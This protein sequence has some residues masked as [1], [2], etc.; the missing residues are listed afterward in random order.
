MDYKNIII[1]SLEV[2]Y[3]NELINKEPFKAKA[4]KNV[5]QQLKSYSSEIKS[6]DDLKNF[7]G[8][9]DKIYK[10]CV[11][12]FE[13]GKLQKVD[14][15]V[16]N[17]VISFQL[18]NELQLIY[19]VGPVK[20]N[21]LIKEYKVKSI[22]DLREKCKQNKDILNSSQKIGLKYYDDLIQRIPR[23]EMDE[24]YHFITS[25]ITEVSSGK[26]VSTLVG[27]YRRLADSS[28][29][30]D[31][32]ITSSSSKIT[33][34]EMVT[35]YNNCINE[36]KKR[37]YIIEI[38]ATG[39]KKCLAICCL[40]NSSDRIVRRI[41][42]LLTI[43]SEFYFSILYFTGSQSFNIK[44]RSKALE[45]GYSLNEFGLFYRNK[46]ENKKEEKVKIVVHSEKDIFN[47]L[48]IEYLKPENRV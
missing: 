17:E 21:E 18:L 9:G 33:Y 45:L 13:T 23:N 35:M 20:A 10:K 8:I 26:L 2:L 30:I 11:E 32:I 3:K 39:N 12:I 27:S 14:N 24:H 15:I 40:I 37:N 42:L 29:D 1:E 46:E 7:K 22:N 5:I 41:D 4:Y 48:G 6:I 16:K 38:L 44:M 25:L 47:F 19:G 31:V 28:G 43:P 34:I 36:F